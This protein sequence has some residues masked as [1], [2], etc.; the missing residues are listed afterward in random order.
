LALGFEAMSATMYEHPVGVSWVERSGM[1]RTSHALAS[2]GG[3][4]LIDPFEDEGALAAAAALGEPRAVIQ[5]LDRHNRDCAAIAS[6]LGVPHLRLPES[7]PDSPFEAFD[8]VRG[9]LWNEV[10]L[11]WAQERA[12]IVAEALGTVPLFTV[13]RRLGMHPGLRA[14]P[15]RRPLARYRPER[16]FVGHGMPLESGATDAIDDALA[17]ARGDVPKLLLSLPK[18]IRSSG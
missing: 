16:L 6:R 3:V 14:L 9:R 8:V 5:L 11:W 7:V 12:L 4:W 15:P 1:A 10:A 2:G 17:H 13:G 18:L